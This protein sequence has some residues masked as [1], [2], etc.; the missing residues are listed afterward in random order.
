MERVKGSN[1]RQT[2]NGANGVPAVQT[3]PAKSIADFLWHVELKRQFTE[4]GTPEESSRTTLR[5]EATPSSDMSLVRVETPFVDQVNGNPTS[6]HLEDIKLK[7]VSQSIPLQS[8]ALAAVFETTFPTA[9]PE[10]FGSGKYQLGP[11]AELLIPLSGANPGVA[12]R[13]WSTSVKPWIEQNFSVAGNESRQDLNST[14]LELEL[15]A[16]WRKKLILKLTPKFVFDWEQGESGAVLELEGG[17]NFSRRW[18]TTLTLG[19]GLWNTDVPATYDRK[20]EWA[21]KF[22]F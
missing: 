18:R 1:P 3:V 2:V 22:N 9:Q 4:R 11:G 10:S 21:V 20:I 17:W 12:P 19:L 16:E 13:P 6:P 8:L 14:K 15:K 5:I 7:L